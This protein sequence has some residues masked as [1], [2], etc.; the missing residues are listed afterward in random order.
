[1][2]VASEKMVDKKKKKRKGPIESVVPEEEPKSPADTYKKSVELGFAPIVVGS[3]GTNGGVDL[4]LVKKVLGLKSKRNIH[5]TRTDNNSF[6]AMLK[7]G[8]S[9]TIK[10]CLY[11]GKTILGF[12]YA[13][14]NRKYCN[15]DCRKK[16][17]NDRKREKRIPV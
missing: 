10:K 13:V 9:L 7:Q 4:D 3:L 15:D 2:T 6:V 12:T 14:E 1:M 8:L 11:C 17:S 5:V 16:A